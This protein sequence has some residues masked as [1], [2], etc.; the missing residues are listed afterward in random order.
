MDRTYAYLVVV[1][2]APPAEITS[3]LGLEPT[4]AWSKDDPRIPGGTP[5]GETRW[6]LRSAAA[7]DRPW[8]DHLRA[9][10]PILESRKSSLAQLPSGCEA[11]IQCVGYFRSANPGFGLSPDLMAAYGRVGLEIDFDIYPLGPKSD[12]A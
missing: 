11:G 2:S 4:K 10:L 5:Y 3:H 12:G 1:G 8:D 7:E 6:T 9:L